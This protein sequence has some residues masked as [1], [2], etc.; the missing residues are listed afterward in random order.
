MKQGV[1]EDIGSS[2]KEYREATLYLEIG[3]DIHKLKPPTFC[4]QHDRIIA[5]TITEI[6]D[7]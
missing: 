2:P 1:F 7:L 6:V 3:E 4:K 5:K